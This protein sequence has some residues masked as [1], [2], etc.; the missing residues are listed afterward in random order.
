MKVEISCLNLE[1]GVTIWMP[2][3]IP[4][5]IPNSSPCTPTSSI[6][7]L[8]HEIPS[9]PSPGIS[10]TWGYVYIPASL[11]IITHSQQSLLLPCLTHNEL[12]VYTT[13]HPF[14]IPSPSQLLESESIPRMHTCTQIH[15]LGKSHTTQKMT[16][17]SFKSIK[18]RVMTR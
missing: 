18:V 9:S 15:G 14:P 7:C 17:K 6:T 16:E 4:Q 2:S 5:H 10:V 8:D 13:C 11:P 12:C 1:C 3:C